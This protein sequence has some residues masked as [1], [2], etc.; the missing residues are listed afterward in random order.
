MELN[1]SKASQQQHKDDLRQL[2]KLGAA[3]IIMHQQNP[4]GATGASCLTHTRDVATKNAAIKKRNPR[5]LVAP[6]NN[7]SF[8]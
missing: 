5:V 3:E 8:P 6:L 7:V 1:N 2:L 4:F